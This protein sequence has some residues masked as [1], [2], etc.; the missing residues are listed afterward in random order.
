V[1]KLGKAV[2]LKGF[3]KLHNLSDFP[4]QFKKGS[5]YHSRVGDLT[6]ESVNQKGEVKFVGYDS[7]EDTAILTNL[8]LSS[9]IEE[10]SQACELG[11]NE[12]FWYDIIGLDVYENNILL[13]KIEEIERFP[14]DDHMLIITAETISKETGVKRFLFPY[15][16]RTVVHVDIPMKKLTVTGALEIIEAIAS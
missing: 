16:A 9:T 4:E 13:G 11:E 10:S 14:T 5:I 6:I 7:K 1:A 3:L 8:I 2:G 12:F 15:G